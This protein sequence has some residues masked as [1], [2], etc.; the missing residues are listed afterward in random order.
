MRS[1][2]GFSIVEVLVALV[3]FSIGMLGVA[4]TLLKS[5]TSATLI[6]TQTGRSTTEALQLSL[7]SAVPYDSLSNLS[8]CTTVSTA[9]FRHTRCISLTSING[10]TGA[11]QIRLIITPS[12]ARLRADTMYLVRSKG[13]TSNPLNY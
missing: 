10:G 8:G 13:A 9:P 7:L 5:A 11:T 12:N 1:R 4:G 6:A 2:R 3:V